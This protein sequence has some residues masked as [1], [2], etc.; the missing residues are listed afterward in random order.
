MSE[1]RKGAQI[2]VAAGITAAL[3]VGQIPAVAFAEAS[4][5]QPQQEAAGQ[6]DS[7]ATAALTASSGDTSSASVDPEAASAEMPSFVSLI[8]PQPSVATAGSVMLPDT[9]IATYDDGSS[10][11]VP[12]VWFLD[13][14]AI[15][16]VGASKLAPGA[17]SFTGFVEGA[18]LD[19][20]YDVDIAAPVANEVDV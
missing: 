20:T 9:V 4:E 3:S 11:E 17:Y 10:S 16:T 5:G 7:V 14:A 13:G 15:D 6:Q 8:A 12:V 1:K 2:V 19:V 18:N